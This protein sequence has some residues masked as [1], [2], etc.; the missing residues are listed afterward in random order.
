MVPM[1][2]G[3]MRNKS[4]SKMSGH[5]GVAAC[6]LFR[7]LAESRQCETHEVD[8]LRSEGYE[9]LEAEAAVKG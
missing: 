8:L 1:R 4:S 6:D 5:R 2:M 7:S 9:R 3:T